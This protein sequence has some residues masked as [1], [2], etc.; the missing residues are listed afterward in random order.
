MA[1][2]GVADQWNIDSSVLMG[3]PQPTR[4]T[5]GTVSQGHGPGAKPSPSPLRRPHLM[6]A[7]EAFQLTNRLCVCG[8]LAATCQ[9]VAC[10]PQPRHIRLPVASRLLSLVPPAVA[11]V[12]GLA[13]GTAAVGRRPAAALVSRQP[14][15]AAP[16]CRLRRH[17]VPRRRGCGLRV[18]CAPRGSATF[19]Q[20]SSSHPIMESGSP[21][22][23][24]VTCSR[25]TI[26]WHYVKSSYVTI[27][28]DSVTCALPPS[29]ACGSAL[30]FRQMRFE[31]TA[32]VPHTARSMFQVY[33]CMSMSPCES[34]PL[35]SQDTI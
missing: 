31:D 9:H 15:A 30:C 33:A 4:R 6:W 11:H 23:C 2:H 20:R 28:C 12:L 27:P 3:W 21:R 1:F 22:V 5:V 19:R 24:L 25:S 10:V 16:G 32:G 34:P 26:M 17:P 13:P 14:A 7:Q 35:G 29:S 8:C 18:A